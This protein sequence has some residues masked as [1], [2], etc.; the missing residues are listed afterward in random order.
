MSQ[1]LVSDGAHKSTTRSTSDGCVQEHTRMSW[2]GTKHD[3]LK[4]DFRD[5]YTYAM[6]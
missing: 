6:G 2:E 5:H 3:C 1:P 4:T